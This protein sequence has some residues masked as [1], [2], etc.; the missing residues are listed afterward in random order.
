[1][2]HVTRKVADLG[3]HLTGL[4]CYESIRKMEEN[5]LNVFMAAE[6]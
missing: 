3:F 4:T 5:N 1:M 2:S 6:V